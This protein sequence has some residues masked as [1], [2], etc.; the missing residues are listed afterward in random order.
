M[1]D[2]LFE[3]VL[4]EEGF[5]VELRCGY[6][7]NDTKYLRIKDILN[8]LI[9]EWRQC[10][11]IPKKAMLAIAELMI[12]LVGGNRFLSEADQ[13]KSEDAGIEINCLLN[14]LYETL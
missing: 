9:I 2:E 7:F 6:S 10:D 5:V 14:C 11:N 1:A 3:L 8:S 4:G 13:L 12:C